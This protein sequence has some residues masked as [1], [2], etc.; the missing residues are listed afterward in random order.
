VTP[1]R[2]TVRLNDFRR[3]WRAIGTDVL[4][5]TSRVGESGWYVLGR[6]VGAFEEALARA[7]GLPHAVGVGNGLDAIEIGLRALG[8]EPGERVL[9][10]PLTA[11]ATSLAVVRAGGVP[12]YVDVDGAGLLD[13]GRAAEALRSERARGRPIRFLLPVHLYGRAIDLAALEGLRDEFGLLVVEDCAQSVGALYR[14][15]P[16]GSV[17][18]V[19]ATSFYPTKNLGALGDGGAVLTADPAL[20][21]KARALRD[22]GQSG[23]YVHDVLGMN[24]RLD[25]LHAAILRD[26]VLP[27]LA[28]DTR[29]RAEVASA[30][31]SRIENPAIRLPPPAPGGESVWHLFPVVLAAG[32]RESF[33]RHLAEAGVESG[34]HYPRLV[35][36]QRA[37]DGPGGQVLGALDVARSFAE[38][39]VSLP[40]HPH[41]LDAEVDRVVDASNAWAGPA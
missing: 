34:V 3:A 20:A 11:F 2:P 19:A 29:R 25:E 28:E 27:R 8:L 4:R 39:E 23:K 12:A 15:R 30:Y 1:S 26:A 41:L 7:W 18:R 38:G 5:A 21:E 16:T 14:G 22:Y 9:T 13:L 33:R 10:T 17:G 37:L 32:A 6:E 24:S 36:E 35:P 40:I 31:L